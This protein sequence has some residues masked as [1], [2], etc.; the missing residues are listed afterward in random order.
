MRELPPAEL[1]QALAVGLSD[2][3]ALEQDLAGGRLD[4]AGDAAHERRLAAAREA[5][6]DEDLASPDVERNVVNGDG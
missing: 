5:H 3:L 6:D 1:P 4:E 2:V